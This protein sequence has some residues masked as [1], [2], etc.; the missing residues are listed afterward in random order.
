MRREAIEAF[1]G[2]ND[3]CLKGSLSHYSGENKLYGSKVKNRSLEEVITKVQARNDSQY[4]SGGDGGG[5]EK[6]L[7]SEIIEKEQPMGFTAL[8]E[9][10][11]EE[12]RMT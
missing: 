7:N 8:I 9:Y 6:W 1:W 12:S 4:H 2:R 3:I 10:Q 5:S 11:R